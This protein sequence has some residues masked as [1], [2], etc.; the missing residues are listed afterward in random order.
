MTKKQI[1]LEEWIEFK[2]NIR[3]MF[4]PVEKFRVW[5]EVPKKDLLKAVIP[6]LRELLKAYKDKPV[7]TSLRGTVNLIGSLVYEDEAP[8]NQKD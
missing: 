7:S 5:N 4:S 2:A 3:C 8:K 6:V 1:D